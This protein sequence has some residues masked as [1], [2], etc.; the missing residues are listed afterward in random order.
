MKNEE[1]FR[2]VLTREKHFID[3]YLVGV[4][5]AKTKDKLGTPVDIEDSDHGDVSTSDMLFEDDQHDD[6]IARTVQS[7]K[8][9]TV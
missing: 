8:E 2:Q 3:T 1:D 6:G 5:D 4:K 7:D 9:S